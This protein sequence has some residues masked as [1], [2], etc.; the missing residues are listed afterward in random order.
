MKKGLVERTAR[1]DIR[2][3]RKAGHLAPG[4]ARVVLIRKDREREAV[5]VAWIDV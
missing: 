4:A 1:V 5:A 3:L 2:E